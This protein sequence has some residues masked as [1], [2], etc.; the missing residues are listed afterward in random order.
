MQIADNE[1][2]NLLSENHSLKEKIASYDA[3]V[4]ML[5]TV[6]KSTPKS[7]PIRNKRKSINSKR[8]DFTKEDSPITVQKQP[9]GST[10]LCSPLATTPKNIKKG[11]I[12]RPPLKKPTV[13][14]I[15]DEQARGM[16]PRLI[17]TRFGKW[18]DVYNVTAMLKPYASCSQILTS[19]DSISNIITGDDIIILSLGCN[20]KNPYLLFTELCNALFKFKDYKILLLNVRQN[21]HLNYK[22]LNSELK[23]LVNNYKNCEF[24]DVSSD[25]KYS[26]NYLLNLTCFKLNVEIDYLK[27]K[28]D[29]IENVNK[30]KTLN[31]CNDQEQSGTNDRNV[32]FRS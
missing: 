3:K 30:F 26:K 7:S 10:P 24:V 2:D 1:I 28:I 32:L 21:R 16:A 15:G 12:E 19:L 18:N 11:A 4:T 14:I 9:H 25:E 29:Y 8:L 6:C 23:L 31:N 17:K 5:K 13:Y 20:D 22:M 27:Y